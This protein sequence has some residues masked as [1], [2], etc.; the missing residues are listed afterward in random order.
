MC[1]SP[2]YGPTPTGLHM[3]GVSFSFSPTESSWASQLLTQVLAQSL[4]IDAEGLPISA[5]SAE[6]SGGV[7]YLWI[8]MGFSKRSKSYRCPASDILINGTS[9]AVFLEAIA[10]KDI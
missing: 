3:S 1:P 6:K 7:W 8:Q 9:L 4:G 10:P 5:V 2:S